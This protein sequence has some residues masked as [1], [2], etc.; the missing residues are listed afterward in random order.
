MTILKAEFKANYKAA[1]Q[2]ALAASNG[3]SFLEQD[4]VALDAQRRALGLDANGAAKLIAQAG[5]RNEWNTIYGRFAVW[6]RQVDSGE[7][8]VCLSTGEHIG[9]TGGYV[10]AT[11]TPVVAPF[12][13]RIKT[14]AD[15]QPAFNKAAV[16]L[17]KLGITNPHEAASYLANGFQHALTEQKIEI[18]AD[19][20]LGELRLGDLTKPQAIAVL[21]RIKAQL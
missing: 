17:V 11:T 3:L 7:I 12:D 4:R 5:N 19:R 1:Q 18:K 16:Q 8:R 21:D 13:G 14:K 15:I 6:K 9:K 20:L 2:R 10:R